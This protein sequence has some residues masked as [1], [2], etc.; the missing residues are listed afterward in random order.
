MGPLVSTSCSWKRNRKSWNR[1]LSVW[2][3]SAQVK[4]DNKVWFRLCQ[5]KL[6]KSPCVLRNNFVNQSNW[7]GEYGLFSID[8]N[9]TFYL[10]ERKNSS[11]GIASLALWKRK[12]TWIGLVAYIGVW[13][14]QIV[15]T[16]A[17]Y[18]P[19]FRI[20]NVVSLPRGYT[21]LESTYIKDTD[22]WY[23]SIYSLRVCINDKCR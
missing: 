9:S 8:D 22:T 18:L 15:H 14:G 17:K 13:M 10:F 23:I 12:F 16:R 1:G 7:R 5:R 2:V 11:D 3:A 4:I 6:F 19:H 21:I 20:Y